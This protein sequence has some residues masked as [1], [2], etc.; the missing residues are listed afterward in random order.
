MFP[1]YHVCYRALN[2]KELPI[3][4]AGAS[5][6]VELLRALVPQPGAPGREEKLA[7]LQA[8]RFTDPEPC[9][10]DITVPEDADYSATDL[11]AAGNHTEFLAAWAELV[12]PFRLAS[13]FDSAIYWLADRSVAWMLANA[14]HL[15]DADLGN[16]WHPTLSDV[17]LAKKHLGFLAS[18][19]APNHIP[20]PAF[21]REACLS[22]F[23]SFADLLFAK[24]EG[25]PTLEDQFN[26]QGTAFLT[27]GRWTIY[28]GVK[29]LRHGPTAQTW[30]AFFC[31]I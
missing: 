24:F 13:A 14:A 19:E 17:R 12:G 5:G 1:E 2:A 21:S 31:P 18:Q 7:A 23:C 9:A 11:A 16:A 22:C 8:A 28:K 10:E 30:R 3:I 6:S 29:E 4:H 20:D 25:Y 26:D 27:I 15:Q